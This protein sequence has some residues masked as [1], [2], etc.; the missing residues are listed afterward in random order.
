MKNQRNNRGKAP[1]REQPRKDSR[2]KRVNFDNTRES[3]FAKDTRTGKYGRDC[4]DPQWYA[5]SSELMRAA[6]SLPFSTT[7]GLKSE[8]NNNAV[9]GVMALTWVPWVEGGTSSAIQQAANSMYSFTAHANSRNY[10]Y[11]P[12]D[13]MLLVVA[14][15]SLF[16]AISLGIRAFGT[17]QRF[18]QQDYYTPEVL[19][20]AM[21]F[22]YADLRK[23]LSRM[24]FDLNDLI[25]RS[26]QIWIPDYMPIIQRWFW[27]NAHIYRDGTSVK[28]QYYLFRP[29]CFLRYQEKTQDT[30]GS[31]DTLPWATNAGG[32]HTWDEYMKYMDSLF[33]NLLESQDRGMIFGDILKAY[34]ADHIFALSPIASDYSVE[35]VYNTEVLTQIENCTPWY[36]DISGVV[37]DQ[38]GT[39]VPTTPWLTAAQI[40][41]SAG[42]GFAVSTSVL[43]FH[44]LEPPTPEQ[45][46]V[47]TR[48]KVH[49]LRVT[50]KKTEDQQTQFKI[51]PVTCG[52][53]F[54]NYIDMYKWVWSDS[55]SGTLTRTQV[56]NGV[57][58]QISFQTWADWAAFDWAPWIYQASSS[59]FILDNTVVGGVLNNNVNNAAGDYD[60]YTY[61]NTTTLAKMHTTAVYSLFGV[62]ISI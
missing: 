2:D 57:T 40:N 21:G 20:R 28:A 27:L 48:L 60:N 16:S 10:N 49:G 39:L 50:Q 22:D 5:H 4:N 3:K 25:N 42:P 32:V 43:N 51:S 30:G 54:I 53:E 24:W 35:P 7:A 41:K 44:Q 45:I 17:M 55:G 12:A 19:V 26:R 14:G 36:S 23:N 56:S 18:S 9:P 46:M 6:A 38:Y 59:Q 34:G 58:G 8:L 37:Q 11:D 47:A 62:P 13:E 15:A 29:S 1:R 61:V 33:Q 31:L 52:T